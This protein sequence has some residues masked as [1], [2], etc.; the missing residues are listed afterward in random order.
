MRR[1]RIRRLHREHI[2]AASKTGMAPVLI[3]HDMARDVLVFPDGTAIPCHGTE[4]RDHKYL[5]GYREAVERC[6]GGASPMLLE[7]EQ[8]G[9][10]PY[11][12][13][14]GRQTDGNSLRGKDN[15]QLP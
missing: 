15:C 11:G 14:R 6:A 7:L 2:V 9:D 4:Q 8:A 3:D 5:P 1:D 12:R 10:S 13:T